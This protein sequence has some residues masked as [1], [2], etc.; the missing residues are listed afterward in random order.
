MSFPTSSSQSNN[1]DSTQYHNQLLTCN[2][3]L[4]LDPPGNCDHHIFPIPMDIYHKVI[5]KIKKENSDFELF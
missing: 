2:D 4:V 5:M 1:L 3:L